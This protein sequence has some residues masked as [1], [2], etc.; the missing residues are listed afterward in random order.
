MMR[1]LNIGVEE[2]LRKIK[3]YCAYRERNHKEVK[4]KLYGFGLYPHEVEQVIAQLIEENYLN[5]ERYA[6]QF[7]GGKFRMNKWG[8]LKIK[9]ALKMQGISEWCIKMALQEIPAGDYKAQFDKL[10]AAKL[11]TLSSERSKITRKAKLQAY[12]LQKGFEPGLISQYIKDNI[13][14]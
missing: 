3:V 11:K 6:M 9:Q 5:E 14:G 4:Q 2:A 10:A 7:A 13:Q 1:P 12:L 8:R